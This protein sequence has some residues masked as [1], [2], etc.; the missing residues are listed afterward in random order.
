MRRVSTFEAEASLLAPFSNKFARNL[1]V[2]D[3]F[4]SGKVHREG[5]RVWAE[6]VAL[7]HIRRR[8]ITGILNT[9][10]IQLEATR[11]LQELICD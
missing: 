3:I 8:K 2:E 4:P 1:K 10:K 11:Q 7:S 9:E 5:M 6:L